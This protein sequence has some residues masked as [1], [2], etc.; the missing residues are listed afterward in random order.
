MPVPA[1]ATTMI[2]QVMDEQKGEQLVCEGS[3]DLAK[4][5]KDGEFDGIPYRRFNAR[6]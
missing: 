3:V 5:L 1:G 2:V 6:A 4:V